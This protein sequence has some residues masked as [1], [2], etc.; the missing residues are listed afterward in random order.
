MKK[1]VYIDMD[2]T[3]A[4]YSRMAKEKGIDPRE[5]KHVKGFF[6]DLEPLD[7]AIDAYEELARHFDVFILSTAPWSNPG[8]VVEKVEWV[9]EYLPSAHKNVIFS[10]RKDLNLGDYLIDDS[11]RNGAS[12]FRGEH[13]QFG[14]PDFPD[15]PT[16]L[17]YIFTKEGFSR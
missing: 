11:L 9:K 16:V 2:D 4:G 13:I 12:S 7:H 8:A 6:R 17:D 3:L 1:I 10:H 14:S 15:W 5:A